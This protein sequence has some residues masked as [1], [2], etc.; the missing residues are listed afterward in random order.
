MSR[1][2]FSF[3]PNL[4][5]ERHR[6]AWETLSA[7]PKGTRTDFMVQ[8]ILERVQEERFIRLFREELKQVC[9]RAEPEPQPGIPQE[10][11][12]FLGRLTQEE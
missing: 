6:K 11:L 9:V 2:C 5:N 8:A 10:M 12:G 4:K 1:P 3:R 7:I